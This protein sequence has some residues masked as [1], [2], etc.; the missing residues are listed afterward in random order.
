MYSFK[1]HC[2]RKLKENKVTVTITGNGT[3]IHT[4]V[5]YVSLFGIFFHVYVEEGFE[6]KHRSAWSM[7]NLVII[8]LHEA[9]HMFFR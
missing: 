2:Y 1:K 4:L 6:E 9:I 8:Q 7:I 3:N 5:T